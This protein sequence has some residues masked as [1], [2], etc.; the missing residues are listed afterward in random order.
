M[1]SRKQLIPLR[2]D[3]LK[4][5]K[6]GKFSETPLFNIIFANNDFDY[7][8]FAFIVSKKVDKSSVVR[9]QVKRRLADAVRDLK[10]TGDMIIFA[11]KGVVGKKIPEVKNEINNLISN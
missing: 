4:I 6:I 5:K 8:R 10:I 2:T 1:L 11:K 9:H 7:P 3:F